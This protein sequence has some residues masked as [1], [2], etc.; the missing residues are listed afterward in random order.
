LAISG[1]KDSASRSRVIANDHQ[2]RI[3]PVA[4]WHLAIAAP[5][6][7]IVNRNRQSPIAN[8]IANRQSAIG[9]RQSA[10][11]YRYLHLDVFTDRP[12]EGNQL[13]VFPEPAGLSTEDMQRVTREMNF[14][15]CTF[16]FPPD[17]SQVG[18]GSPPEAGAKTI[19]VRMRIFTPG[20]ELPM[21]GH[22]TIGSTFALALEG[23]IA[24]GQ[25]D[26]VFGLGVGPTPVSLEWKDGALDFAWMTQKTPEFGARIGDRATFASAL[27]VAVADLAD[28][29]PQAVSCG[30]PFLFAPLTSRRAVDAVVIDARQY[31]EACRQAGADSLPLFIF[32]TDRAGSSG[33]EAVYSRM[34][35]S[36]LGIAEDPATGGASGPLGCYLH[37]YQILPR[38]SLAHIVSMQ[39]V[40]MLRPSRIHIA[41]ESAGDTITRVRVGGRS[42]LVGRGTLTF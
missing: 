5:Q 13:A 29:P 17:L 14:S 23:T 18:A 8:S 9:N 39:G 10:M 27:G 36:G 19:D 34:L 31:V 1:N 6:S 25:R 26:F 4:D 21:A 38:V 15:E 2:M 40:K 7:T 30:V 12:L 11:T 22:P 20:E 16:I 24:A 28:A 41:I 35:A 32:T 42:V 37:K 33:D 3:V